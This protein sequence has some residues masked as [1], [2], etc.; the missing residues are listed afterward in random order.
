M[1]PV[2]APRHWC[3]SWG[4]SMALGE[5]AEDEEESLHMVEWYYGY[6]KSE[7][8]GWRIDL[9][10]NSLASRMKHRYAIMSSMALCLGNALRL[11]SR[12]A[13]AQTNGIQEL[14][15]LWKSSSGRKYQALFINNKSGASKSLT[16][17]GG[18]VASKARD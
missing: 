7:K 16:I 14:H 10:H 8:L 18:V 2:S 11:P 6:G 15:L 12:D 4:E 9:R 1:L 3:A 17:V 13:L 5:E